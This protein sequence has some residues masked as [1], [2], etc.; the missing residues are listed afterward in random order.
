MLSSPSRNPIESGIEINGRVGSAA[1]IVLGAPASWKVVGVPDFPIG[2]AGE[3]R[4]R[5][6]VPFSLS[7]F[8]P[9][10]SMKVYRGPR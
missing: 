5:G 7:L 1:E 2:V 6:S 8:S 3:V 10:F 4:Y 9:S